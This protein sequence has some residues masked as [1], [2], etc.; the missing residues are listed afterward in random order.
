MANHADERTP[1]MS[2]IERF[3]HYAQEF[4]KTYK[5][6]DWS[7][8][9]VFFAD[10]AVYEV[11]NAPFACR[12]G[13]R[14]AIFHA[15]RKSLNGFDRRMDSR[16]IELL[17]PPTQTDDAVQIHWA[18]TYTHG[19]QPPLRI[20]ARTEARYQGGKIAYLADDYLDTG[21]DEGV[22]WLRQAGMD[23]SYV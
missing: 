13:G 11:K 1:L 7:R 2:Q 9:D 15:I 22:E 12:V 6:D 8:L 19:D 16:R 23:P 20:E 10:D 14:D 18:V 17:A 3:L 4:E 21:G 5:D